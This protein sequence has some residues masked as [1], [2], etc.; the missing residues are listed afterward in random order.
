[1]AKI[2]VC[3]IC[4]SQKGILVETNRRTSIKGFSELR[5]DVCTECNKALPKDMLSY[6]KF[7]NKILNP[8]MEM[9]DEEIKKLYGGRIRL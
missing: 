4:K 5:L 8:N 9:T 3:D 7:V 1:M 6:I 2:T